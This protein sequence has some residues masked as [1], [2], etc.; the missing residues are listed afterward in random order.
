KAPADRGFLL[1]RNVIIKT[2]K[3]GWRLLRCAALAGR[4]KAA[5]ITVLRSG[6][7]IARHCFRL[8]ESL[9]LTVPLPVIATHI[10]AGIIA[11]A[12]QHLHFIGDNFC[13]VSVCAVLRLPFARTQRAFNINLA[14]FAQIF[15]RDLTEAVEKY[16]PV[17]LSA[18]LGLPSILVL[19][20]FS[21]THA[22]INN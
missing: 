18:L 19:P 9:I 6:L 3:T 13:G 21:V 11:P 10:A 1:K 20:A 16:H 5:L 22:D 15:T 2:V 4:A 12:V 14:A 7:R 8:A 17:P